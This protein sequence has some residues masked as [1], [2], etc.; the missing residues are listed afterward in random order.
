MDEGVVVA[1]PI[2]IATHVPDNRCP[3]WEDKLRDDLS[4]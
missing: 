3:G 4:E 2:N 1:K